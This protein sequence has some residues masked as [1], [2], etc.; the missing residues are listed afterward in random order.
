MPLTYEI[1]QVLLRDLRRGP[2][3]LRHGTEGKER[4]LLV[5]STTLSCFSDLFLYSLFLFSRRKRGGG[6]VGDHTR[7]CRLRRR[8]RQ[9]YSPVV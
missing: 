4:L 1:L 5:S 6:T 3:Q 8:D 7:R 9:L 2:T